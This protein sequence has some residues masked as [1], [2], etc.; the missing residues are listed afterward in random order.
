MLAKPKSGRPKIAA[1]IAPLLLLGVSVVATRPLPAQSPAVPASIDQSANPSGRR[2]LNTLPALTMVPDDFASA[3]L[4][5]GYLLH[6]DI[7]NAPE[8]SA[9]LRVDE[10]GN[11]NVPLLG[12]VHVG[13][14]SV[15]QAETTIANALVAGQILINPQV[16][17]NV[18][19]YTSGSI[20][21]LGEVQTPGR[22]PILAAKNLADVLALA[23]GELISAG[24]QIEIRHDTSPSG[25]VER[26]RYAQGSSPDPLRAHLV[27]PGDTVFVR[28][29][30]IV[31][32][33]GAV[34]RPG[35]YFMV[36]GGSLNVLQAISLA[37]GTTNIASLGSFRLI[38]PSADGQ[39]TETTVPFN[40]VTKGQ[41]PPMSLQPQDILY[42]PTNSFKDIFINGSA[43]IG[44]TASA[45]IYRVP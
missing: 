31:Y 40:K 2:P 12:P 44:T 6:L 13:G 37:Y 23:G 24:N 29:A 42:V 30:G 4:T 16:T 21:V 33:L 25:E 18:L 7:F 41:A 5:P 39:F 45:A 10:G 38:R 9:E 14:L 35:G 17:L 8:M 15:A 34:N 26:V 19:Q 3:R 22:L 36:D 20:T 11:L 28:R 27:Y 1:R 32:I 43:I